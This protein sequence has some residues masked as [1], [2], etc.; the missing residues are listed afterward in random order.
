MSTAVPDNCDGFNVTFMCSS[1]DREC[2]HGSCWH[3]DRVRQMVRRWFERVGP[4]PRAGWEFKEPHAVKVPMPTKAEVAD[5]EAC[6]RICGLVL[7]RRADAWRDAFARRWAGVPLRLWQ[8]RDTGG[9]SWIG[10]DV[11]GTGSWGRVVRVW[12]DREDER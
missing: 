1:R 10:G 3:M 4:A 2:V 8:Y 5:A 7:T 11:D 9:G 6:G 12:E